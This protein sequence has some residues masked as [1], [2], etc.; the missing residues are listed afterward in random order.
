MYSSAPQ[1]CFW[2]GFWQQVLCMLWYEHFQAGSFEQTLIVFGFG[3]SIASWSTGIH[4]IITS[5]LG[6]IHVINQR[7]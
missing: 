2:D 6:G 5:F 4:D 7:E 3:I 1:V